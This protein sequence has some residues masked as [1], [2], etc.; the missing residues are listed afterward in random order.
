M[1]SLLLLLV[2]LLVLLLL[3]MNLVV[4]RMLQVMLL[5]MLMRLM[6]HQNH[7]HHNNISSNVLRTT[8]F[9]FSNKRTSSIMRSNIS[10]LTILNGEHLNR[11]QFESHH[12]TLA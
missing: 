10:D 2:M 6:G 12:L 8:K 11:K 1:R 9:I 3:K 4:F 7:E 5:M